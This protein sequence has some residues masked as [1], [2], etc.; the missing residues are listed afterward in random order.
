MQFLFRFTPTQ[1][2]SMTLIKDHQKLYNYFPYTEIKR[3]QNPHCTIRQLHYK[4]KCI[5]IDHYKTINLENFSLEILSQSPCYALIV[6]HQGKLKYTSIDGSKES[7][8]LKQNQCRLL[9]AKQGHYLVKL[10]EQKNNFDVI[11]LIPELLHDL[12]DEFDNLVQFMNDHNKKGLAAMQKRNIDRKFRYRLQKTLN[13]SQQKD[14]YGHLFKELPKLLSAYKG[15]LKGRDPKSQGKIR[16]DNILKFIN[17]KLSQN[18][19]ITIQIILQAYY[20]SESKLYH[21]F[22]THLNVSPSTYI[23]SR[24][25]E[26]VALLLK[27]STLSILEIALKSGYSDS[28]SLSK[29]F[30]NTMGISPNHYR[31]QIHMSIS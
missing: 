31:K 25:M 16:I 9:Y 1:S 12:K 10:I 24:K 2:E 7:I 18:Q 6:L 4:K 11:C 15:L 30:K 14:F 13:Y 21:L 17:K 23:Q 8:T 29:A 27:T 26:H 19:P 22:K 28:S 3:H 5:I 20:L